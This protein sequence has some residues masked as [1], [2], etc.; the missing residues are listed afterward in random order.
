[1]AISKPEKQITVKGVTVVN[2]N[3]YTR[4]LLSVMTE[5]IQFLPVHQ[6]PN[7]QRVQMVLYQFPQAQQ[8]I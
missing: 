8:S 2:L 5:A 1:M 4:I 7:V 6:M 3:I